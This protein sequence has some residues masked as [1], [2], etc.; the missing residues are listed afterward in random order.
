MSELQGGTES[1]VHHLLVGMWEERGSKNYTFPLL[2]FRTKKP[3]TSDQ[4]VSFIKNREMLVK[5][6]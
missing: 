4:Y 3:D 5:M 1:P 2:E 6:V